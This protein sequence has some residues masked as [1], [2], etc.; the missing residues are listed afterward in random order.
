MSDAPPSKPLSTGLRSLL[1][2]A[3]PRRRAQLVLALVLTFI[4]AIAELVTI[5]AVV[6][7]ILVASEPSRAAMIPLLGGFLI[8]L[9]QALGVSAIMA[10]ALL[11]T[12]AA[13][14]ATTLR[15]ALNWVSQQFVYGLHQDLVLRIFG[16][17]LRQPYEWYARQH[18]SV[19]LSGIEKVYLVAVGVVSPL[20]NAVS[21]AIMATII[22]IFL[23]II[24]PM[25]ALIAMTVVGTIYGLITVLTR[26]LSRRISVSGARVRL[27]RV[28]TLQESLGGIR[29]IILDQTHPL[30]E[31]KMARMEEEY[32]RL[33]VNSN[34]VA[35]TPRLVVEGAVIVLVAALA[36]WFNA[37]PGGVMHA[38][39]VLGALALGAQRLLPMIQLVYQGYA[40]YSLHRGSLDDVAELL[41]LP[42]QPVDDRATEVTARRFNDSIALNDVTFRYATRD[43]LSGVQLVIRKGERIGIIGKTGSGKS[44]LVDLIMGLLSPTS[45]TVTIDGQP[46]TAFNVAGW[47]AQIAHV[48]QSIFLTDDTIAANIAFG[49]P[50]HE[51]DMTR[52]ADAA[53]NAGLGEYLDQL[54]E[55]LAAMI[56]ERGV[57]L[58]GGQRQ[59]IGIARALYKNATVLVLDE[60]TSALDDETEAAVMSAVEELGKELT[61]ILI[62]HRL[63]TVAN[64]DRVYRLSGGRIVE[65]GSYDEVV[66]KPSSDS[67]L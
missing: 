36:L 42:V 8:T 49:R 57:R 16:R 28:K 51:V 9:T 25:A 46:L 64:C 52:V 41:T 35:I 63:S 39:P 26:G 48:P 55:G 14:A 3:S 58:S 27:E 33:N 50:D 2:A 29:D 67:S 12:V 66:R 61:I 19:L 60:A 53:V 31:A 4:G 10:A 1:A 18:S 13:V 5:G 34:L 20:V 59:R 40:N 32:R 21:A 24:N 7:M 45:G 56:G 22:T 47:Q 62:A 15:I 65:Q 30:F 6:P 11:L 38:L 44:T 43:A 17:V 37:Q 23:F 54:P